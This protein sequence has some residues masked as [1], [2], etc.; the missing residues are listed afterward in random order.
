M[1]D[2]YAVLNSIWRRMWLAWVGFLLSAVSFPTIAT[3]YTTR[4]GAGYALVYPGQLVLL[5]G[6]VVTGVGLWNGCRARASAG[7]SN[8][9]ADLPHT[10]N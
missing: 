2:P 1:P 10:S 5:A 6:L 9:S 7:R 3:S 8:P 4:L